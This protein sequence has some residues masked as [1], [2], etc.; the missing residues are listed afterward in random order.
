MV[1]VLRILA[2]CCA[3]LAP[4]AVAGAADQ[5]G[6]AWRTSMLG[7]ALLH[8]TFLT[9]ADSMFNPDAT[10]VPL[11]RRQLD[12]ELRLN[13]GAALGPCSGTARLRA[14]YHRAGAAGTQPATSDHGG[15]VNEGGVRCRIGNQAEL[16]VGR[17]VL[18]W[19]SSIFLSPSNPFFRD[20]G[21]TNP[22]Q[23]LYGKD[24]W[25]A[26]WFPTPELTVALVRVYRHG[27]REP[28]PLNFSPTWAAK[29]DWMGENASGG[30]IASR[31]ENGVRRLGL[32]GTLP[33]SKAAL[34]YADLSAGRGHAGWFPVP[35]AA[36]WH[37]A[38]AKLGSGTLF[39]SALGGA[40]YTFESGWTL[41]VEWLNGNEGYSPTER[42][43]WYNA[44][45]QAGA[46]LRAG[47]AAS[48][49]AFPALGTA[50][51]PNLP[52]VSRNYLFL[53]LLRTEWNDKGDVAL[54]WA[55]SR[56]GSALSGSFTYY[57]GPHAQAFLMTSRNFGGDR[58][59][60]GRLIKFSVQTGIR[61]S[62]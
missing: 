37:F 24:D 53:Q 56:G 52:Y 42:Q 2:L 31:Q 57:L 25:Q 6:P 3:A 34:V 36:G 29:L 22:I 50:L 60:F 49:A 26:Q 30:A 12:A 45:V 1:A 47:G 27:A 18:Q 55:R 35:D 41:N 17:D 14:Q 13:L 54:R 44:A 5:S 11:P 43:A 32:Y 16:S 48:T 4:L 59:D 8:G 10:F 23:E 39:Y 58:S 20:T 21:K 7:Q 62:F 33:V 19:G 15:F 9:P 28:D 51:S 38:Q 40:A 46:L 61:T